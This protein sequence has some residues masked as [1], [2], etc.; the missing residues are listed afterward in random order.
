MTMS[1]SQHQTPNTN[2]HNTSFRITSETG[3]RRAYH[4]YNT[5][6][7]T[8]MGRVA[9]MLA[10]LVVL[11]HDCSETESLGLA[12]HQIRDRHVLDTKSDLMRRGRSIRG[13]KHIDDGALLSGTGGRGG[14]VPL[15]LLKRLMSPL[16]CTRSIACCPP[17]PSAS[18]SPSSTIPSAPT[19][20]AMSSPA[21]AAH[22]AFESTTTKPAR[23]MSC[24][25]TSLISGL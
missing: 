12:Q 22:A 19:F 4:T 20:A 21:S 9:A 5:V 17:A 3:R 8:C 23:R 7:R 2:H 11:G 16:C 14:S 13:T 10:M 24:S 15:T 25:S 18:N 6:S 1:I